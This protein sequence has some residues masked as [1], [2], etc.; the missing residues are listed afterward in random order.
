MHSYYGLDIVDF[1]MDSFIAFLGQ[2]AISIFTYL[3][4]LVW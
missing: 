1:V 4:N 3:H 2:R